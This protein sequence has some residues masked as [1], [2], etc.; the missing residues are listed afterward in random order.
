MADAAPNT[1]LLVACAMKSGSTFI[2]KVLALYFGAE[3]IEPVPYWGRLEQNLHE[4]LIEPHLDHGFVLQLHVKPHVSNLE[5]IRRLGIQVVWVWRNLGDVI[6]SFDDHIRNEDYRNPVCYVHDRDR[7]LAMPVQR[8]YRYLID[9][10]IPWYIGFWLGWQRVRA[11][12]PFVETHYE[13]LAEDAFSYFAPA[14]QGLGH[15]VDEERMRGILSRQIPGTRFNKGVNNRSATLL[16]A[17]NKQ[18]L[19]SMLLDHF[20]DLRPLCGELPWR[21]AASGSG[22]PRL[23]ERFRGAARRFDGKAT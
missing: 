12:L 15:D 8:R 5:L 23:I 16:S 9:H 3:R 10:A 21:A 17:E 18:R 1:R 14:I 20:E 6:V 7:Y 22:G 13:A 2:A 11:E 19:E 4:H